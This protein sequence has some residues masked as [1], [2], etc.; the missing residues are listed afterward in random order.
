[1]ADVLSESDMR[2]RVLQED[3]AIAE[4]SESLKKLLSAVKRCTEQA[5]NTAVTANG[6]ENDEILMQNMKLRSLLSTKRYFFRFRK[7]KSIK[8]QRSNFHP[9]HGAQIKQTHCGICVGI[10]PREI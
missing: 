10:T 9:A 7:K 8:M 1:M 4:T 6:A 3:G 5:F 2:Q